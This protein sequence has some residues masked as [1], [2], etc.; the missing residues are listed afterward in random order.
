MHGSYNEQNLKLYI[1]LTPVG[2]GKGRT[3]LILLNKSLNDTEPLNAF[4]NFGIHRINALLQTGKQRTCFPKDHN[5]LQKNQRQ[6]HKYDHTEISGQRQQCRTSR[7]EKHT[8][9]DAPSYNLGPHVL[10]LGNVTGCSGNERA[11]GKPVIL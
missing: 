1:R 10:H 2:L 3:F 7:H 4:L 11:D 9:A 8:A 6:S 5:D